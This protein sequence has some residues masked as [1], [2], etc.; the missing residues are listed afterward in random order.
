MLTTL[1]DYQNRETHCYL[2]FNL[3]Y[4]NPGLKTKKKI[5]LY[6]GIQ[7]DKDS[8]MDILANSFT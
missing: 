7:F 5:E 6:F 4:N 3:G 1:Y 2:P 8:F